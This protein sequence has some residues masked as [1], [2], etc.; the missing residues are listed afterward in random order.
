M[1][2]RSAGPT[3]W[4]RPSCFAGMQGMPLPIAAGTHRASP[5]CCAGVH[6]SI[7]QANY[8]TA[9]AGVVGLTKAVAKEWGPF[10]VRCNCLT[11]G[12][13]NTRCGCR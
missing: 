13:I 4:L 7:G 6:G 3:L 9:K 5:S 1:H 10:G 11:Y 2:V 12:Y 8:A